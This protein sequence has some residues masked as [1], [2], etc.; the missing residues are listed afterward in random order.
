MLYTFQ[1]HHS[2]TH[3][4]LVDTNPEDDALC[5]GMFVYEVIVIFLLSE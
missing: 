2:K 5:A 1:M 3:G 4:M